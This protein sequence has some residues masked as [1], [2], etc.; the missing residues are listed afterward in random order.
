M[1]QTYRTDDGA[2]WGSGKGSDLSPAEVDI[3]FWDLIQRMIAQEARP[4]PSAGIDHFSTSGTSLYVHMTDATVLGPY[5]LPFATFNARG[6]WTVDTS[7][8]VLDTFTINGGLYVVIFDHISDDTSFDAGAN[9]GMGHD[10]YALMIQTPGSALPTGG[11][12]AQVLEKA[13]TSDFVVTWGWKLPVDGNTRQYLIKQSGTNQDADWDTPQAEDIEF[14]PVTGSS[15]TS[16]N[17]ADALEELSNQTADAANVTFEPASGSPYTSDNVADAL[18]EVLT[19]IQAPDVTFEPAS[20]SSLTSDNVADALE[21]LATSI[22]DIGGTSGLIDSIQYVIDGGG[23][24]LSTGL[25]GFIEVPFAC[26]IL[27]ARLFSDQLGSVVVDIFKCT[28]AQFDS[29]VTHPLSGDKITASTPLTISS[30]YKT[31]DETLTGWTTSIAAESVLGFNI[32]S[33]TTIQRVTVVL[34]VQRT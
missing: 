6:E 23:T 20:G 3:N 10:Y 22:V 11:A 12:V 16:D 31:S 5:D 1:T 18:E 34:K 33:A 4:D 27:E 19:L 32:N 24:V 30:T 29:G 17:V 21:E 25:K 2:R 7:Y 14:T 28:Y 15:L 8:S 13:T 26:T 9:D